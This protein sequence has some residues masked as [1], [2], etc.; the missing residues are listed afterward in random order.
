MELPEKYL[1]PWAELSRQ[2]LKRRVSLQVE[3]QGDAPVVEEDGS[4][5]G[6]LEVYGQPRWWRERE[7]I[8]TAVVFDDV[9]SLGRAWVESQPVPGPDQL[10]EALRD[11]GRRLAL[12]R[13]KDWTAARNGK[14]P[15]LL[16]E[17]QDTILPLAWDNL[18]DYTRLE[19][20]EAFTRKVAASDVALELHPE[21]V[22]SLSLEARKL[23][24]VEA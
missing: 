20:L 10:R 24:P 3:Y 5:A 22:S 14:P 9:L 11:Y 13:P 18:V 7:H 17:Y 12:S 19:A 15:E 4:L 21:L 8:G 16:R 23:I 2:A 6:T 1:G